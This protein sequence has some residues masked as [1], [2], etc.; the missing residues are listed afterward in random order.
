MSSLGKQTFIGILVLV[1]FLCGNVLAE[2][3]FDLIDYKIT[4]GP[5]PGQK[6]IGP[7]IYN[8][9]VSGTWND[10]NDNNAFDVGEAMVGTLKMFDRDGNLKL[11]TPAGITSRDQLKTWAEANA[12]KILSAIFD[13]SISQST[14][15]TDDGIMAQDLFS[16]RL[17]NKAVPAS[18]KEQI[19]KLNNDF[20]GAVEYLSVECNDNDGQAGSLML[21]YANSSKGGLELGFY[22]PYRYSAIDDEISSNSHFVGLDFYAKYPIIKREKWA[23]HL[24][25]DILGDIYYLKSD[26]IEHAGDYKYGGG[27]FTSFN[28]DLPFGCLGVGLD[29]KI[30]KANLNLSTDNEILDKATD[31]VNDLD[32]VQTITYGFN[33]GVPIGDSFAVNLEMIRSNF[34]SDDIPSGRG[35]QTLAGLSCSYFPSDAF[36]LN[37]GIHKTFELEDINATGATLGTI[38]RF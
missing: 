13:G 18:K 30:T 25:A 9:R 26:I 16:G 14:G 34:M 4:R 27:L 10:T 19:N 7:T 21:G 8:S 38:Y 32:P 5:L 29:Y 31:W 6:T 2:D 36:E 3:F 22:L 35:S 17:L 23:W 28:L 33:F 15:I 1:T 24:G 11:E 20:K 37:L 12:D